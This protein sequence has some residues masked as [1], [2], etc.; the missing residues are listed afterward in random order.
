MLSSQEHAGDARWLAARGGPV[1]RARAGRAA[2]GSTGSWR[3]TP[4]AVR[5]EGAALDRPRFDRVA[6]AARARHGWR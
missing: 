1:G 4:A 5:R 6:E 2:S 3:S